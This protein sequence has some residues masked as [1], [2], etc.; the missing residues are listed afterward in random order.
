MSEFAEEL[1]SALFAAAASVIGLRIGWKKGFLQ[2]PKEPAKPGHPPTLLLVFIAFGIYLAVWTFLLYLFS[3]GT[4]FVKTQEEQ[5]QMTTL[6]TFTIFISIFSLL[7]L[8]NSAIAKPI[9]KEILLKSDRFEPKKD[10]LA[11]IGAWL[12]SFPLVLFISNC[13]DLLFYFIYGT[14][15]FPDQNA[16]LLLKMT[17]EKPL[18][19]VLAILST[20]FLAPV[21][22]ETLFRGF[23]QSWLRR[24][25]SPIPSIVVSSI[26]FASFHYSAAQEVSNISILISLFALGCFLGFLYEKR[27]SLFAPTLLHGLFNAI[28]TINLYISSVS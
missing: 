25:L 3:K 23:L 1:A 4:S 26:L 7:F 6:A 8:Y 27:Q 22:E 14:F 16:V 2:L 24:Y 10:L 5:T 20:V 12:I 19:L 28:T 21:I 9:Q 13:F 18:L 17:F 15:N 11:A